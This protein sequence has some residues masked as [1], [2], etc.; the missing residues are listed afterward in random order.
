VDTILFAPLMANRPRSVSDVVKDWD[1]KKVLQK[2]TQAKL[3]RINFGG[4]ETT[5]QGFVALKFLG[6]EA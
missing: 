5:G 3:N 1:E 6:G 4:D 2:V